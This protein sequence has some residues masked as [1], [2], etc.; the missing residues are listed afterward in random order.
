MTQQYVIFFKNK[1]LIYKRIYIVR[2]VYCWHLTQTYTAGKLL[3]DFFLSF[4]YILHITNYYFYIN[5]VISIKT[6][7]KYST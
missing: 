6:T 1:R 4:L 3:I 7:I 2:Q 5:A